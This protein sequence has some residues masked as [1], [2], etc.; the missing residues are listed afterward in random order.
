MNIRSKILSLLISVSLIC[1]LYALGHSWFWPYVGILI[2]AT[3]FFAY[4]DS[5]ITSMN[6]RHHRELSKKQREVNTLR[7][8]KDEASRQCAEAK[9]SLHAVSVAHSEQTERNRQ[10]Q[11]QLHILEINLNQARDEIA[12]AKRK[13]MPDII[14]KP[15]DDKLPN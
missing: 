12:V 8:E 15:K 14:P 11:G 9:E 5:C 13:S 1:F 4:H 10:L 2:A 3:I 6:D 7:L